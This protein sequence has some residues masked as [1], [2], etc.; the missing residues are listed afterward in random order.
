M[1]R[2]IGED[3]KE[4]LF[5]TADQEVIGRFGNIPPDSLKGEITNVDFDMN[6]HP[7]SEHFPP[8]AI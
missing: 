4:N 3:K 2:T 6:Y 7:A 8:P 5:Y 1:E